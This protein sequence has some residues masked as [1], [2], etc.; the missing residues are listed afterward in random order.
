MISK[1]R[2]GG[3]LPLAKR[4]ERS[5]RSHRTSEFGAASL[6]LRI[7]KPF[8]QLELLEHNFSTSERQNFKRRAPNVTP[9]FDAISESQSKFQG[10]PFLTDIN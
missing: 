1:T 4:H 2:A 7:V 10:P 8:H 6:R 9:L 5:S 3:S